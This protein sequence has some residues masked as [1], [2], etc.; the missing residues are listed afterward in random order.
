MRRLTHKVH[1]DSTYGARRQRSPLQLAGVRSHMN[2]LILEKLVEVGLE[3]RRILE[4]GAGDS[5]WLP[6]IAKNFPSS[7]CVG[8]DYSETGCALL[9]ERAREEGVKIDV[10]NEDLFANNSRL[11]RSFDVVLSFGVVEH[12]DDLGLA[13][14]TKSRY[15]KSGGMV[16]TLIPNMAGILGTLTRIWN[17]KIYDQHNPHN[18]ASFERGHQ[19]AHLNV[20]TGGYLGSNSFGVLSSCFPEHKGISWHLYR[21]LVAISLATWSLEHKVGTLPCSATFSP[22]MY[23]VSR[24]V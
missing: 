1:W 15:A 19:Q 10:V 18:W 22:Y 13:L 24:A 4:V 2:R 5:M 8:L 6:F 3:G 11:H 12:F 17:R 23:A 20:V 14:L 9:A 16:F 21:V 7:Q